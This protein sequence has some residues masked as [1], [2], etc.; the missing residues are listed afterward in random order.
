MA[1]DA[2]STSAPQQEA[3]VDVDPAFEA[4]R[5]SHL[6]RVQGVVKIRRGTSFAYGR[7]KVSYKKRLNPPLVR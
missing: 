5:K 1:G 2:P 6:G 4:L 7:D 3:D